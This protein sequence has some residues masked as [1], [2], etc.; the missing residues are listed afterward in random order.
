MSIFDTKASAPGEVPEEERKIRKSWYNAGVHAF[1]KRRPID[2]CLGASVNG[3][4]LTPERERSFK[5]GWRFAA[6][7]S[8]AE[9]LQKKLFDIKTHSAATEIYD[10]Q[11][12]M[13]FYNL[14][15]SQKEN[16]T[17]KI[18]IKDRTDTIEIGKLAYGTYVTG[19]TS[20]PDTVYQKVD[21]RK[22]GQGIALNTPNHHSVIM[23]VKL[24]SLRV[25]PGDTLVRVYDAELSL[26]RTTDF[27]PYLKPLF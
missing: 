18:N 11:T 9:N 7:N 8:G 2:W 3:T 15:P 5:A 16:K 25:I 21:K 10:P 12:L 1:N 27:G 4:C 13:E 6:S 24:G 17:M 22:T 19:I 20:H 23:N 26:S 14:H